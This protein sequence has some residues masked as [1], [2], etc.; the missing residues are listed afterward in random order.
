[1]QPQ[2][3]ILQFCQA[4]DDFLWMIL[5]NTLFYFFSTSLDLT[6]SRWLSCTELKLTFLQHEKEIQGK[7]MHM[8]M[9]CN[10]PNKVSG[11]AEICIFW[12]RTGKLFP[13]GNGGAV[14]NYFHWSTAAYICCPPPSLLHGVYAMITQHYN[15]TC[16]MVSGNMHT[17]QVLWSLDLQILVSQQALSWSCCQFNII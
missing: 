15:S 17:V 13:V 4:T 8:E 5:W 10:S 1:M 9:W 7:E 2:A 16:L 12:W 6:H 11:A 3:F 14:I